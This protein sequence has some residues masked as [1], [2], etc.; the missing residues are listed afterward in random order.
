MLDATANALAARCKILKL[1][2]AEK[3]LPDPFPEALHFARLHRIHAEG[4]DPCS[5]VR[6]KRSPL[7]SPAQPL[8]ICMGMLRGKGSLL[9]VKRAFARLAR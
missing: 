4:L 6:N 9:L 7:R 2:A 8:R 1:G 5:H 3:L